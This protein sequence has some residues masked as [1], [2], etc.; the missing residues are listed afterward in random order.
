MIVDFLN[1]NNNTDTLIILIIGMII[2]IV[3]KF[4][5]NTIKKL[6]HK[7]SAI[8]LYKYKNYKRLKRG[9]YNINEII[10]IGEKPENKRTEKEKIALHEWN[11]T[12]A[13]FNKSI[14]KQA[15]AIQALSE[16]LP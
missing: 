3:S 5:C 1:R 8:I 15:D 9:D 7:M 10:Q 11:V 14:S 6:T 4:I 2:P 13:E 12:K 16:K